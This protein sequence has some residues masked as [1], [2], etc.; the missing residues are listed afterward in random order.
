MPRFILRVWLPDRPGALG[1]VATRVGAARGEIVGIDI[2]E[3][4][5]GRAIDELVV[6]LPDESLVDLLVREVRAADH[7]D[8][9]DVRRAPDG[10]RD[11]AI[12]GLETAA[13]LVTATCRQEL[14]DRLAEHTRSDLQAQWTALVGHDESS[15]RAA[16]G[17][18]PSA[19]WL[20]A[21]VDGSQSSPS[22]AVQESGPSEVAWAPLLSAGLSLV[23]GRP[24][25]PFRA[26]ERRQL[27]VLARIAD[28][29]WVEVSRPLARV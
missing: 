16:S 17:T 9:E 20:K 18:T 22:L 6:E 13:E 25:R 10:R 29:R 26:L 8:V 27:V 15:I 23:L 7:V 14:L 1:V 11:S 2:L 28:T 24:A 3:R 19:S 12:A 21:F 5:A 4:G